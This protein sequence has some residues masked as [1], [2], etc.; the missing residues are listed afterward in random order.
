MDQQVKTLAAK[1]NDEFNPQ[2]LHCGKKRTYLCKLCSTLHKDKQKR[3]RWG[4]G[5]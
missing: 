1:L 2:D 5:A 3:D 4:E